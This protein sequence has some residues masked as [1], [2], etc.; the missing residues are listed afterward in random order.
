MESV[1]TEDGEQ[2]VQV[3]SFTPGKM[4]LLRSLTWS[5]N[6]AYFVRN[7]ERALANS[8]ELQ[9][10]TR[11]KA[12]A[13]SFGSQS[14]LS[15]SERASTTRPKSVP[16]ATTFSFTPLGFLA[17]T[18]KPARLFLTPNQ[19]YYLL[20]R[21]EELGVAVGPLNGVRL[22]HIGGLPTPSS[23][24]SFLPQFEAP[25]R[26]SL[27]QDS[28]RSVSS[29]RN[30]ISSSLSN[31]WSNL[32]I[33]GNVETRAERQ[34]AVL[35]EDL[36]YLYSAFTKIP[37]AKFSVDPRIHRIKGY[38]EF[39]FDT[40]VP[41]FVFKNLTSLEVADIDFRA[42]YGWDRLSEQL[43][44]LTL[45]RAGL[46]DPAELL[47]H[48]VLDDMEERRFRS[49]KTPPSPGWALSSSSKNPEPAAFTSS[50]FPTERAQSTDIV[51]TPEGVSF[52]TPRGDVNATGRQNHSQKAQDESQNWL[53]R[54]AR[55]QQQSS[56]PSPPRLKTPKRSS[57]G[58]LFGP[59]P[60]SKWRFLRHL[61]LADNSLT[62]ISSG[63][64]SP[65]VETLQS[66]DLSFNLFT[67]LPEDLGSLVSLRALNMSNCMIESVQS[68]SQKPL[69]AIT[70]FNLRSNRVSSLS[71]IE[72]LVSL[73]RLDLR[74]NNFHDPSEMVRLTRMPNFR[75]VFIKYNP[76][77]KTC[78][79]HR[80]TVFN[81]FR[82]TPGYMNDILVDSS[83]PSYNERR[84]LNER[85]CENTT[86]HMS[87]AHRKDHELGTVGKKRA[88]RDPNPSLSRT[89]DETSPSATTMY[90]GSKRRIV[91][92]TEA[93]IVR[94]S[95]P[96][97]NLR[98]LRTEDFAGAPGD[99]R[100]HQV[101]SQSLLGEPINR[102]PATHTD[103]HND[104]QTNRTFQVLSPA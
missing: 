2:F 41:L 52:G 55:H 89:E 8:L 98:T 19:L 43:Q 100:A 68:L 60:G 50:Y 26:R 1:S 28:I 58:V 71:G 86:V 82:G 38:E 48:I 34:R 101:S 90:Q 17:P 67:Q 15:P 92:V 3:R 63:S 24:V 85:I 47:S 70:V 84:H 46:G 64:L 12:H 16:A 7:H 77:E 13:R 51:R 59:L 31:L 87:V 96:E 29:V 93:S 40:A 36:K 20:S 33:R 91:D 49:S 10:Q 53:N 72:K 80:A 4:K 104:K 25:K 22:E 75:E 83:G 39:P 69:P 73:E 30:S 97:S 79:N 99:D 6:L 78:P 21:F 65:L 32:N 14:D 54:K 81:L 35:R 62:K 23:Y 5:Q 27:S 76:L 102:W 45:K 103:S 61:S 37:C 74:N 42:F 11:Y 66:L 56:M 57:I 44:S 9:R 88:Q 95:K 18:L 94:N